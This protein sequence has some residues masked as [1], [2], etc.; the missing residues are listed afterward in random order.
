MTDDIT[1]AKG[2]AAESCCGAPDFFVMENVETG[3]D[4]HIN[5]GSTPAWGLTCILV[6]HEVEEGHR[7]WKAVILVLSGGLV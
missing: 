4:Q 2:C 6:W 1:T 5:C 7:G 3:V